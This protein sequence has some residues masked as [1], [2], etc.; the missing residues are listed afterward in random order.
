MAV[1]MSPFGL[2]PGFEGAAQPSGNHAGDRPRRGEVAPFMMAVINTQE[3]PPLEPAHG[4]PAW[5][6]L[7]LRRNGSVTRRALGF[8]DFNSLPGGARKPG[9]GPTKEERE[10]GCFDLALHRHR[11]GRP[12]GEG[13]GQKRPG[14]RL[15]LHVQDDRRD[16]HLPRSRPGRSRRSLDARC[17]ASGPAPGSTAA[18]CRTAV[19]GG[20]VT[21]LRINVA[22]VARPSAAV[23]T[24]GPRAVA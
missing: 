14:S 12:E 10:A 11:G 16:R 17:S 4:S 24:A 20:V 18:A 3:R 15:R 1:M 5:A 2:T 9:E 13:L 23:R 21:L 8:T 19:R 6:R 22:P 7:R